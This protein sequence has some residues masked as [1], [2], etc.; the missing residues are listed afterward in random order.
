MG[1]SFLAPFFFAG[2]AAVLVP[3]LVHLTYRQKATVVPFPSLMFVQKVPFKSMR[4]QKIRHWILFLLRC[5]ALALVVLAFSRPFLNT[6]SIPSVL[7]SASR[8]IVILLDNSHS[9]SYTGRWE[10]AQQAA[11]EIINDLNTSDRVSCLLY[12]SP[13]PRDLSTSRMPSSA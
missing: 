3:I 6:A 12:T 10:I 9:M 11:R 1:L 13:S 7:S 4:R 2:L 8:E 5:A